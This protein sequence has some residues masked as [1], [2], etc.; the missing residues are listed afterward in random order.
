M[1]G[2]SEHTIKLFHFFILQY[3]EIGSFTLHP[4]KSRIGFAA[5]TRFGAIV[6]LGKN[7][8]DGA[9]TFPQPYEDNLCFYRIGRVPDSQQYLHYFRIF[10]KEDINEELKKFMTLALELGKGTDKG[11]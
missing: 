8:I 4:T 6:R 11:K 9:L 5:R 3:Q 1:K 7:F 2:K 10:L